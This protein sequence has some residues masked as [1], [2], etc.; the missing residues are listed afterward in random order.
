[1]GRRAPE[2][3]VWALMVTPD[4]R[5]LRVRECWATDKTLMGWRFVARESELL[6]WPRR[7]VTLQSN[8]RRA[9]DPE[10]GR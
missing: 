5:I 7:D 2:Q 4:G 1:M 8:P 6:P 10:D 3:P 9:A